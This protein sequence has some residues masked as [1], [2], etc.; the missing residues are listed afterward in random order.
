MRREYGYASFQRM[1]QLPDNADTDQI[2]ASMKSD[3]LKIK[4]GK[5]IGYRSG[6]KTIAVK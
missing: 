6:R 5:R 2:D 4:V 3:E 1:F